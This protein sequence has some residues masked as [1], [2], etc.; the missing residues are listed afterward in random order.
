MGS[1]LIVLVEFYGLL[2]FLFCGAWFLILV[3][4]HRCVEDLTCAASLSNEYTVYEI[5]LET[6]F[7]HV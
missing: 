2:V 1:E 6:C 4:S 3:R 7:L 5:R